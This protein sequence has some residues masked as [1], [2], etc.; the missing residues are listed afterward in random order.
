ME[1]KQEIIKVNAKETRV[2]DD[3]NKVSFSDKFVDWVTVVARK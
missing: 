2:N 3:Y 1:K